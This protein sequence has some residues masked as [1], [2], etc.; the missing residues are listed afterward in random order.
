M[1]IFRATGKAPARDTIRT[2]DDLLDAVMEFVDEIL[3][4]EPFGLAGLSLNEHVQLSAR[5]TSD[6]LC[7]FPGAR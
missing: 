4:D 3:P 2:Q 5:S 6:R 1:P 7:P